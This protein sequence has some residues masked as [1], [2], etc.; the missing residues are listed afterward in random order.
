MIDILGKDDALLLCEQYGGRSVKFPTG[1]RLLDKDRE[2]MIFNLY[3]NGETAAA[4]ARQFSIAEDSV[5]RIVKRHKEKTAPKPLEPVTP[6]REIPEFS[7]AEIPK[8]GYWKIADFAEFI[9]VSKDTI[10]RWLRNNK[11]NK[12]FPKPIKL[13]GRSTF[14]KCADIKEWLQQS[15][16]RS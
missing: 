10:Y 14:F 16:Q 1:N 5:Y 6:N 15:E 13:N 12:S 2:E 7:H 11:E 8:R 9:S 3:Q 4:L